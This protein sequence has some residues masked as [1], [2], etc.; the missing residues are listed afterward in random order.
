VPLYELEKDLPSLTDP[1]VVAAFDGWV[2]AA[3]AA[4]SAMERLASG[5][6]VVARFDIDAIY[7]YRSRRPVLDVVDGRLS[8]L[9]WPELLLRH[10][11][12]GGRDV[13]LL[14]GAEP[15]L[16][17]RTLAAEVRDLLQRLGVVQWISLGAV[18]AT[19]PHTRPVPVMA[20]ASR[21]GL[22]SADDVR[23]P[24][25]LL[26]VPSAALSALE[27]EVTAA[28]IPAVGFFAQVPPYVGGGY[29]AASLALLE[30]VARH[31]GITLDLDDLADLAGRERERY[32]QAA[33]ADPETQEMITRLEAMAGEDELRLPS[34]DELAREI[35]RFLR[36]RSED[37]DPPT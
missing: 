14:A 8:D 32:D 26:R 15:D 6:A 16:Q 5:S 25:G 7:D 19:V 18:P 1:V 10:A 17:W 33:A 35:Q 9:V 30:H 36:D 21:D 31:L 28:G 2:D 24:G 29:A 12:I 23:R 27:L 13:L 11:W 37:D 4:S 22:L 3:A 20:T 34:G